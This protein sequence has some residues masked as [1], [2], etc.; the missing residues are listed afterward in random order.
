MN[1]DPKTSNVIY[2]TKTGD[3]LIA[4]A[5]VQLHNLGSEPR[6]PAGV[7]HF[8]AHE[9]LERTRSPRHFRL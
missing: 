1:P 6:D 2:D 5:R 9:F 7:T 3:L 4:G 8:T